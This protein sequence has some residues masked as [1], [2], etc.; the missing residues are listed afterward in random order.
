MGTG[1]TVG[2]VR[3]RY[4]FKFRVSDGSATLFLS[5]YRYRRSVSDP[6]SLNS[7]PD[8]AKIL[9]PDPDDPEYGSRSQLF[10][11]LKH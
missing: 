9:N 2:T 1:D 7:D 5:R 8:P 6:Y 10:L 3:Y 11:N 4:L